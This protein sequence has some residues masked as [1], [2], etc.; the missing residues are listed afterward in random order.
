MAYSVAPQAWLAQRWLGSWVD[1]TLDAYQ[2]ERLPSRKGVLSEKRAHKGEQDRQQRP[3]RR[4]Q[5]PA[6]P[7]CLLFRERDFISGGILVGRCEEA[8]HRARFRLGGSP[9]LLPYAGLGFA[10]RP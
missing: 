6:S 10:I 5:D 4:D 9:L 3:D 1:Q 2:G 8:I 7:E